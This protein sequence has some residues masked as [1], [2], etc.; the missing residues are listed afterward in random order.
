M[1]PSRTNPESYVTLSH[2]LAVQAQPLHPM[3][4]AEGRVIAFRHRTQTAATLAEQRHQTNSQEPATGERTMPRI[5]QLESTLESMKVDIAAMVQ[6]T[7]MEQRPEMTD[8]ARAAMSDLEKAV[9]DKRKIYEERRPQVAGD[10]FVAPKREDV[11]PFRHEVKGEEVH[12]FRDTAAGPKLAFVDTGAQVRIHQY[13][14]RETVRA[15]LQVSS[16]KWDGLSVKGGEAYKSLVVGLAAEHGFEIL[17]P[18]L[19]ERIAAERER[20]GKAETAEIVKA[21]SE[22]DRPDQKAEKAQDAKAR[23]TIPPAEPAECP[24]LVGTLLRVGE[25]RYQDD[26][27]NDVSPYVDIRLKDGSEH[28]IW[29]VQVAKDLKGADA[30]PGDTI[31]A[32]YR[33]I[34][35]VTKPVPVRDEKTGEVTHREERPME[36]GVWRVEVTS[37][38][39]TDRPELVQKPETEG[40]TDQTQDAQ[41]QKLEAQR[42]EQQ[43]EVRR[44]PIHRPRNR[45]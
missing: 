37:Q 14:D 44:P 12:Y 21:K 24:P 20:L 19:Q 11:G 8:L 26:P 27:K 22:Q 3:A 34:E 42:Q 4:D 10:R 5:E 13:Q 35:R 39:Q 1:V 30:K 31:T 15:A 33:G 28:R 9:A 41:A 6:A 29:S 16:E 23:P 36:R 43:R 18:E 45:Q 32:Q 7:P 38:K 25:G 2:N 17:N 40:R